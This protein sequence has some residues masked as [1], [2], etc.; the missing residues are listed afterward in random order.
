M[1][2]E[3][4]LQSI[5]DS[6]KI[7]AN[8]L[9]LQSTLTPVAAVAVPATVA[10][11]VTVTPAAMPAL[12]VFDLPV[13]TPVAQVPVPVPAVVAQASPSP[14]ASKQEMTDFVLSSYKALGAEKGAKIQDVLVALGHRNIND[15]PSELWAQLKTGID[16]LKG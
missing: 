8:H 14:F 2:I 5:A 7:I 9:T 16:A 12:P 3:N 10:Q 6:L 13:P 15:V 11:Q 1:T 4:N